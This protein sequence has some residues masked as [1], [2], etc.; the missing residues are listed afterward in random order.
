[1]GDISK[2]VA[3]TLLFAKKYKKDIG[4]NGPKELQMDP[5]S[6]LGGGNNFLSTEFPN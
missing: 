4:G 6:D 3:N 5:I 1:M 2:G